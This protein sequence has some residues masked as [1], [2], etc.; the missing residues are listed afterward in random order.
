MKIIKV[1][2]L[3]ILLSIASCNHKEDNTK[4]KVIWE[5]TDTI[6]PKKKC[7]PDENRAS[8]I[9]EAFWTVKY[10]GFCFLN[11]PMELLNKSDSSFTVSGQSSHRLSE[12]VII[13]SEISMNDGRFIK[14][15]LDGLIYLD[16]SDIVF[17]PVVAEK[18]AEAV[19]FMRDLCNIYAYWP[20]TAQIES[21][22]T[23]IVSG[24]NKTKTE[25]V[26]T[27]LKK[28]DG[29]ILKLWAETKAK[30]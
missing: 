8:K 13:I 11:L 16:T 28:K 27:R 10:P 25:K 12:R 26:F 5:I 23:W 15:D 19:W 14:N 7:V 9:S 18:I 22:S 24:T 3:L 6:N 2:I 21:D 20:L 17:S 29:Q 30:E 4:V 1:L